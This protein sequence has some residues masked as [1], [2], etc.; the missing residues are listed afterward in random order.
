MGCTQKDIIIRPASNRAIIKLIQPSDA[1]WCAEHLRRLK[2][3]PQKIV[4]YGTKNSKV[5]SIIH[6]AITASFELNL[7]AI[8]NFVS[9]LIYPVKNY[10][11]L[12]RELSPVAISEDQAK[13]IIALIA[14]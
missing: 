8:A 10:A 5:K 2:F 13:K 3:Q 6:D 4:I 9:P 1:V 11:A 7:P 12:V 14:L